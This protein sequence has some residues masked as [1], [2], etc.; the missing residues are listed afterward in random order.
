MAT[1]IGRSVSRQGAMLT[2]PTVE[3]GVR[4]T[5]ATFSTPMVPDNTCPAMRYRNQQGSPRGAEAVSS[6]YSL[7]AMK[8]AHRG[9]CKC[10]MPR[11]A[12]P[13]GVVTFTSW[14]VYYLPTTP[15]QRWHSVTPAPR[16]D[17][18]LGRGGLVPFPHRDDPRPNIGCCALKGFPVFPATDC[19]ALMSSV[20]SR[21]Y[22]VAHA[23]SATAGL[24][25]LLL[26]SAWAVFDHFAR[27]YI[28]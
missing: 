25:C 26:V 11:N 23:M 12:M 7:S 9:L 10:C 24:A 17:P 3:W 4:A 6:A 22:N 14:G 19:G 20:Y 18:M 2:R 16:S 8:L 15:A 1:F 5:A 21:T 28:I 27:I 13:H